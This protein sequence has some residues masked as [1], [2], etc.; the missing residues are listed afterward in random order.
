MAYSRASAL[1][2]LILF[3]NKDENKEILNRFRNLLR[4]ICLRCLQNIPKK[5][6]E[7]LMPDLEDE[8]ILAAKA[9]WCLLILDLDVPETVI[10]LMIRRCISAESNGLRESL[11]FLGRSINK[12]M[13]D[14]QLL[15]EILGIFIGEIKNQ[16]ERVRSVLA[17]YIPCFANNEKHDFYWGYVKEAINI[18]SNDRSRIVRLNLAHSIKDNLVLWPARYKF[19]VKPLLEGMKKD[20]SFK[21][22][23]VVGEW[24]HEC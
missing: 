8:D 14:E 18:F 24:D 11:L 3:L 7:S 9:A 15:K 19:E 23:R 16:D 1:H 21:V 4:D 6:H 12:L 13:P 22:R 2:N 17:Y 20:L 5:R 10:N